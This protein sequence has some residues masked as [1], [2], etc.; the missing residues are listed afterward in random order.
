VA[1][2][3]LFVPDPGGPSPVRVLGVDFEWFPGLSASQKRRSVAS[4]HAAARERTG[5]RRILEVSS[6]SEDR[7]GVALSAFNLL[8]AAPGLPRRMSVECAF[9]G[10]KVFEGGG[11]FTE[12]FA[13]SSREAKGD[14][15]L[16]T[17]GRLV[18]FRFLDSDWPQEPKTAFYDWLYISAL[19]QNPD[20][21][22][23]AAA[24]SAFTDIEFNPRKSLNC[25]AHSVALYVSLSQRGLLGPSSPD[26][27]AFLRLVQARP[28]DRVRG[29]GSRQGVLF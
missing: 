22:E 20:L 5:I 26:R 16:R 7:L 12:I 21:A 10:S 29:D 28:A 19:L 24:Y 27:D 6:K 23:G 8:L 14:D 17:S 18:G 1:Q 15:R 25:Q 2:R 3:P 11:P 13:M 9:Q 4:L